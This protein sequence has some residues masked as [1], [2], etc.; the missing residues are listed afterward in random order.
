MATLSRI[1]PVWRSATSNP[2]R[3]STLANASVSFAFTVKGHMKALK[4]P[5]DFVI[6]CRVVSAI[7]NVDDSHADRYARRPSREYN[8]SR[9]QPIA[10]M[11]ARSS[12]FAASITYHF[13]RSNAGA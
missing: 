9:G 7:D 10:A 2:T 3:P 4:G 11:L 5:A 1:N 8:A 13:G 12:P 6:S